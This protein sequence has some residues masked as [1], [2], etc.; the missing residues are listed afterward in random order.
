MEGGVVCCRSDGVLD[1]VTD[2]MTVTTC[3]TAIT[4]ASSK[5]LLT[6]DARLST[7]AL[8]AHH[9]RQA[10]SSHHF[11]ADPSPQ[12]R[13]RSRPSPARPWVTR[14]EKYA[15][16]NPRIHASHHR[17][18]RL[19]RLTGVTEGYRTSS[20]FQKSYSTGNIFRSAT[21]TLHDIYDAPRNAPPVVDSGKKRARTKSDQDYHSDGSTPEEENPSNKQDIDMFP[22]AD[23][24]VKALRKP[25]TTILM[26]RSLPNG[27]L[28]VCRRQ[29]DSGAMNSVEE[30][31][32]SMPS[33]Q[34]LLCEQPPGEPT[35]M[36]S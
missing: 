14:Q 16:V 24:P 8:D 36:F 25:R 3:V 5:R 26:T 17:A 29:I 30:E 31:D 6:D 28:P 32:W 18:S 20:A 33:D 4:M 1:A 15:L 27:S 12:H 35:V 23:R 21:D 9:P 34:T 7:A 10:Y 13:S 19:T 2:M 11:L 22:L